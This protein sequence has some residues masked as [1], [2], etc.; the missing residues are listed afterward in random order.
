MPLLDKRS[1]L[2]DLNLTNTYF[3]HT[4]AIHSV[5]I[6]NRTASLQ[7]LDSISAKLVELGLSEKWLAE[8]NMTREEAIQ[9]L[10][11]VLYLREMY[12]KSISN[13]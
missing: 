10:K 4:F 12:P 6:A 5:L 13:Q 11:G 9:L 2:V 1:E 8:S 3:K 7:E